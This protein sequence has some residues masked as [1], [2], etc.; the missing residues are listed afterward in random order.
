MSLTSTS[1]LSARISLI[2]MTMIL[3]VL[4][5]SRPESAQAQ[6]PSVQ[7]ISARAVEEVGGGLSSQS[8][9]STRSTPRPVQVIVISELMGYI[10]PC[11]CTIDLTLGAIE[12]LSAEVKRLKAQGPTLL[13]TAGTQLFEHHELKKHSRAQEVA[14]ARLIREIFSKLGVDAHLPG[15]RDLIAGLDFYRELQSSAPLPEV[16]LNHTQLSPAGRARIFERGGVKIGVFG[17][18]EPQGHA[19]AHSEAHKAPSSYSLDQLK[20]LTQRSIQDLKGL[21]AQVIIGL[22]VTSRAT[23]RALATAHPQVDLWVLSEGAQEEA[24]LSP[25]AHADAQSPAS[26]LI[27]AGDRGRNLALI[28][29]SEASAKGGF[30]DPVGDHARALKKLELKLKMKERFAAR[31]PM[32]RR[33][34][35]QIRTEIQRHRE[36]APSQEGK[37]VTY[38]LIPINDQLPVDE[39]VA[40][41]VKAYQASLQELN[42]AARELKPPPKN[43]NGYAG[44]AECELCHPDAVSFWRE[45]RHSHAWETLVKAKKTFDV[46]CV[47]CHVTGWQEPGGSALGHTDKLKDVQCEACHGPAAKHAEIGGGEVYVKLKVPAAKCEGCHNHKHSPKFNYQSYREKILGP[48]HGKPM[49]APLEDAQ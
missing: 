8:G 41:R 14:K 37:R 35:E 10:E 26:Y 39:P 1:H 48:G 20:S 36:T 24:A 13:I 18:I 4:S 9:S 19:E 44:Q 7:V 43:G 47:S 6:W 32:M 29:L 28:T 17:L 12:R 15:P 45:T 27:E 11:G 30:K 38:R 49:P 40:A 22:G 46:E 5:L 3:S 16:T 42:Q 2:I 33:Q 31:M 21:G 34:V 25:V 23:L